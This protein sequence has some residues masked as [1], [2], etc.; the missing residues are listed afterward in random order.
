M[1]T[2]CLYV[3]TLAGLAAIAVGCSSE[4]SAGETNADASESDTAVTETA[5]IEPIAQAPEETGRDRLS[6]AS[7]GLSDDQLQLLTALNIPIVLPAAIPDGFTVL[8]VNAG[9]SAEGGPGAGPRY[10]VTYSGPSGCFVVESST[11]GFGGPVPPNQLPVTIPIFEAIESQVLPPD[12]EYSVFWSDGETADSPYPDPIIFSDWFEGEDTFY[13]V[14]SGF[15]GSD[16]GFCSPIRR[17]SPE[18]A[19]EITESLNYIE[20]AE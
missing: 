10:T 17:I 5:D 4:S 19:V 13:R 6:A 2:Q 18:Q 12:Y 11:G 8:D 1:R 20:T 3:L 14:T 7:V 16:Y 15:N 9:V